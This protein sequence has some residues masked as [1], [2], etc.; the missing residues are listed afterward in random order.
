MFSVDSLFIVLEL[1]SWDLH[2][3]CRQFIYSA[4]AVFLGSPC[5]V[6]TVYL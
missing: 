5:S 4:R 6:K 2:V 3:Q 1:S